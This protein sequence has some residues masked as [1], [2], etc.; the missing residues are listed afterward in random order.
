LK[1]VIKTLNTDFT[2]SLDEA[3]Q[4]AISGGND[5]VAALVKVHQAFVQN[6]SDA[7]ALGVSDQ[8]N[9]QIKGIAAL[10]AGTTLAALGVDQLTMVIKDLGQVAPEIA[11]QAQALIDSGNALPDILTQA[12]Q[13]LTDPLQLAIEKEKSAG[14]ERIAVA[15]Q[16]GQDLVKVEELNSANMI[17]A[18][19]SNL[20]NPTALNALVYPNNLKAQETLQAAPTLAGLSGQQ[21][22]A[23]IGASANVAP[24]LAALAQQFIIA[25]SELP[26]TITQALEGITNPLKLAIQQQTAQ[27]QGRNEVQQATGQNASAVAA[28]NTASI[29]Q[30]IVQQIS[31]PAALQALVAHGS[32]EGVAALQAGP[33][34]A[35][36]GT[37]Q[38]QALLAAL[39]TVAPELTTMINAL[40]SSGNA[41][42]DALSQATEAIT[43]AGVLAVQKAQALAFEQ[44]QAAPAAGQNVAEAQQLGAAEV[45]QAAAQA[46]GTQV[47]LGPLPDW[48]GQL[49]EAVTAPLQLAIQKEQAAGI[50][51][52]QIAEATGANLV[53]VQQENADAIA[54]I[55]YQA[56]QQLTSLKNE[57]TGGSLSGL[58][59][60]NQVTAALEQFNTVLALVQGGNTSFINELSTAGQAAVQASQQ[61]YGNGPQT[62]S[63]REQVLASISPFLVSASGYPTGQ[64]S[65]LANGTAASATATGTTSD[66][67]ANT[68][69]LQNLTSALTG[70]AGGVGGVGTGTVGA[71]AAPASTAGTGSAT[72]SNGTGLATPAGTQLYSIS[73]PSGPSYVGDLTPQNLAWWQNTGATV[74]PSTG[75]PPTP[76]AGAALYSITQSS[77]SNPTAPDYIGDLTPA[78]VAWWQNA[79]ATVTPYTAPAAAASSATL[80]TTATSGASSSSSLTTNPVTG[81]SFTGSG[82]TAVQPN[83]PLYPSASTLSSALA[84]AVAGDASDADWTVINQAVQAGILSPTSQPG[85]ALVIE[86]AQQ[87][88][89]GRAAN[90]SQ[91]LS[92]ALSDALNGTPTLQEWALINQAIN[93]GL[94]N[95]TSQPQYA[96]IIQRARVIANA[97]ASSLSQIPNTQTA[98]NTL[99]K[100]LPAFAE[101]TGSTPAG[102]ILVGE[103]GPEWYR[104]A[105]DNSWSQV[106]VHGPQVLDQPGGATIIPFPLTPPEGRAFAAGTTD[107]RSPTYS[108]AGGQAVGG[109]PDATSAETIAKLTTI[110]T[111]LQASRKQLQGG[112][113]QAAQDAKAGNTH[114]AEIRRT[115]GTTIAAPVPRRAVG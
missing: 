101:G 16:T 58:T 24:D 10:Q 73:Q 35:G 60:A 84:A 28:L 66:L 51:R 98:Y 115:V 17:Q 19:L 57:I 105:N 88:A 11:A 47:P 65:A 23:V 70:A 20:S 94:L 93:A 112:Q 9:Q 110:I 25:G 67:R 5:F 82:V 32:P 31:N 33:A 26:D 114:L 8:T 53:R 45:A 39:G 18:V 14:Q 36:L 52:V 97:Q 37:D 40:I 106:G 102:A 4:T 15:Q 113:V 74:T 34:I 104:A 69:A 29:V 108:W 46:T 109:A 42:P 100:G 99:I 54:Q 90:P 96:T 7:A 50:Q 76:R 12:I 68:S 13:A 75:A 92:Q 72:T 86:Q 79:G 91:L 95:P 64:A 62:A 78:D 111:E 49:E 30:A 80:A 21:L 44:I 48:V 43:E 2:T 87:W 89:A 59:A 63:V 85:Y 3:F 56:T 77:S 1:T 107:W 83:F 61:A 81:Q 22:T 41:L 55:W 27:A 38:L 6:T 71:A 103:E